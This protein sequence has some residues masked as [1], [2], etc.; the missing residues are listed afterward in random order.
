MQSDWV[1]AW[2]VQYRLRNSWLK[3]KV[4]KQHLLISRPVLNQSGWNSVRRLS[5]SLS[6]DCDKYFWLN[7]EKFCRF[8]K[9]KCTGKNSK[10][11]TV[12]FWELGRVLKILGGWKKS[13][14]VLEELETIL[15]ELERVSK[16]LGRVEKVL[17]SLWEN[18]GV[19]NEK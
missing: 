10:N 17:G 6:I 13:L 11:L 1:S 2:L 19:W 12:L 7:R 4:N 3:T 15:G 8:V 14:G 5:D 18:L 9:K 16:M